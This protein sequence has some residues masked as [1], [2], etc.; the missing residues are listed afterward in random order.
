MWGRN[1][2]EGAVRLLGEG[3]FSLDLGSPFC[4]LANA[5]PLVDKLRGFINYLKAVS[6]DTALTRAKKGLLVADWK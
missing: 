2:E 3:N 5:R 6:E 1:E 4:R